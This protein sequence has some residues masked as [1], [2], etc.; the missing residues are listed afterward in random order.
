MAGTKL[1]N[2]NTIVE[3]ALEHLLHHGGAAAIRNDAR[4]SKNGQT[5][6]LEDMVSPEIGENN[7]EFR[8]DT[9]GKASR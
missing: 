1:L 7:Q 4:T 8:I 5:Q 6:T 2:D 9:S 3:K